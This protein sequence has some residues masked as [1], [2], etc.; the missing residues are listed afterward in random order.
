MWLN[1]G[2]TSLTLAHHS[3]TVGPASGVSGEDKLGVDSPPGLLIGYWLGVPPMAHTDRGSWGV[4]DLG[5]HFSNAY[6]R[7]LCILAVSKSSI[8][9]T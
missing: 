8:R 4:L 2:P 6:E 9:P 7:R 5:Q 3:A 1:D